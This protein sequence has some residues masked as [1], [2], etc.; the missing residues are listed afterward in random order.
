MTVKI[1]IICGT[2]DFLFLFLWRIL[3]TRGTVRRGGGTVR[4]GGGTVRRGGGTVRRGGW[5]VDRRRGIYL[6]FF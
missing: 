3:G 5:A 4:R 1:I 6:L 2:V